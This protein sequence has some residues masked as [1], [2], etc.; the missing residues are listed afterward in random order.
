[1]A[2]SRKLIT[3]FHQSKTTVNFCVTSGSSALRPSPTHAAA[4]TTFS[5]FDQVS[6]SNWA[7]HALWMLSYT[8]STNKMRI[9]RPSHI[10]AFNG[11]FCGWCSGKIIGF[12]FTAEKLLANG[13]LW[14]TL[15]LQT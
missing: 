6:S 15:A 9:P 4:S 12:V 8:P 2:A 14:L 5:L 1:V 3:E 10:R 7:A 13:Y 11:R